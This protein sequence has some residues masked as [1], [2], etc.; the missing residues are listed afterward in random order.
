MLGFK[1]FAAAS[2]VFQGIKVANMIR[3]GQ[4]TSG[5]CPFCPVRSARSLTG[6]KNRPLPNRRRSLRQNRDVPRWVCEDPQSYDTGSFLACFAEAPKTKK[7]TQMRPLI[8]VWYLRA[9]PMR[10]R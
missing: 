1:S 7:L 8:W 3:K 4:I 10:V 5:L 2:A 6:R 9:K